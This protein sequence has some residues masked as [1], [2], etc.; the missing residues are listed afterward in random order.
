MIKL[1]L[2]NIYTVGQKTKFK[3]N[4]FSVLSLWKPK[5]SWTYAY[6][7]V[8]IWYQ[9]SWPQPQHGLTGAH[10]HE[11][12]LTRELCSLVG[13]YWHSCF[14]KYYTCEVFLANLGWLLNLTN[15]LGT[16]SSSVI[17]LASLI[18]TK[19]INIIKRQEILKILILAK[20]P[21]NYCLCDELW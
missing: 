7:W 21:M 6:Q 8:I 12:Y 4:I 2:F 20:F 17:N 5:L 3:A 18:L 11:K 14:G 9:E 15:R 16:G 1:S 13:H 10:F 19:Y